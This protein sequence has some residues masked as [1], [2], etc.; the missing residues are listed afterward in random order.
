MGLYHRPD[1]AQRSPVRSR[2]VPLENWTIIFFLASMPCVG[3]V[4]GS[5][6][7][8]VLRISRKALGASLHF[9]EGAMLAVVGVEL[10]PRALDIRP[11]WIVVA[12]F[13]LGGGTFILIQ[14]GLIGARRLQTRDAKGAVP[15]MI[16]AGAMIDYF[17]DGIMIGAGATIA[18]R[19]G[20]VLALGQTVANAP[21]AFVAMATLKHAGAGSARRS[22][23]LL[24]VGILMAGT[25][26]GYTVLRGLPEAFRLAVLAFGSGVLVLVIVEEITPHADSQTGPHGGAV[27]V[28]AGFSL[29]AFVALYL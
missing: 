18:A 4:I 13:L 20:L 21:L 2:G 12:A 11:P 27:S 22:M 9:A 25:V 15:W 7:A 24:F 26:L 23:I 10:M 3:I 1:A 5:L 8:E 17:L 6:A 14:K 28:L 16:S 19:L 29:F